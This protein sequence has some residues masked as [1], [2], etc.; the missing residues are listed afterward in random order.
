MSSWGSWGECSV[1]CGHGMRS[2]NRTFLNPATKSGD[3]SVDLERKDICVGENGDDCNV[4]PD[5]LC[6]TTA[7]SDWSPCSASC[8]EGVRVRT[9]LFFYSEHEKRCMHVNLQEK[10]TCVMQSCRRFIEINSEGNRIS[11]YITPKFTI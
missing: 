3:C 11:I 4:T 2:R 9:R 5:P 6:K 1:Q 10:D 8:D 7:W